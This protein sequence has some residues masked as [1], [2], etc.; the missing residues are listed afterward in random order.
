MDPG[1]A[2]GIA[3]VPFAAALLRKLIF[4]PVLD[5]IG[6]LPDC[7]VKRALLFKVGD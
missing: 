3:L 1:A 7:A 2:L 4:V 6:R 5:L